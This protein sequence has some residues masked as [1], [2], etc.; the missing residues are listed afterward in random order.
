MSSLGSGLGLRYKFFEIGEFWCEG[1]MMGQKMRAWRCGMSV[2]GATAR[3][4]E[5]ERKKSN[6]RQ[7]DGTGNDGRD[8]WESTI[9]EDGLIRNDWWW[10]S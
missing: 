1:V 4:F 7:Y 3:D 10:F 5:K 2:D 9:G 8:P 6:I